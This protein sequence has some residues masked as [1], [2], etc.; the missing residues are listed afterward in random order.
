MDNNPFISF[1]INYFLKTKIIVNLLI[2]VSLLNLL[3]CSNT[4]PAIVNCEAKVVFD[5]ENEKDT[6][7]QKMNL[8]LKMTSDVRRTETINVNHNSS[9]LRWIVTNPMIS[10]ADNYYYAGY[11]NLQGVSQSGE[12]LPKG[13]YSI[14]FMDGEGREEFSSFNVLYDEKI[15][16]MKYPEFLSYISKENPQIFV[17][18]YSKEL[19]LIYYGKPR[20]EWN[21]TKEMENINSSKLFSLYNDATFFR[22]FFMIDNNIFVM[23]RIEKVG[24]NIPTD[25]EIKIAEQEE[26]ARNER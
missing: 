4:A 23:P 26:R 12:R 14:N 21:I 13:E 20:V 16:K 18:V 17:G 6:P 8:F 11:T 10:Q 1:K 25:E 22:V 15:L 7:K 3:S 19:N 9:G 5:F 24:S 2:C